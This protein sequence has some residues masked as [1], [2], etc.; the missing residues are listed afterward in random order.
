MKSFKRAESLKRHELGE[1][2]SD[3]YAG[4]QPWNLVSVQYPYISFVEFHFAHQTM[5]KYFIMIERAEGRA[6]K[7]A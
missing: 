7:T 6:W 2:F 5:S 3:V 1:L 4:E